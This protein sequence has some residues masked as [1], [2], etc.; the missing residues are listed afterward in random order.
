MPSTETEDL[1]REG[2][3]KKM[4]SRMFMKR[5]GEWWTCF[6]EGRKG[7]I[8]WASFTASG[9]VMEGAGDQFVCGQC[10]EK[11][12]TLTAFLL[13]KVQ[14]VDMGKPGGCPLCGMAFSRQVSLQEH[15]HRKHS[16]PELKNNS[17][18]RRGRPRNRH[19]ENE[20]SCDKRQGPGDEVRGGSAHESPAAQNGVGEHTV[21]VA[22]EKVG[23]GALSPLSPSTLHN[24]AIHDT[25]LLYPPTSATVIVEPCRDGEFGHLLEPVGAVNGVAVSPVPMFQPDSLHPQADGLQNASDCVPASVALPDSSQTL[26]NSLDLLLSHHHHCAQTDCLARHGGVKEHGEDE[27][28]ATF[29]TVRAESCSASFSENPSSLSS[30]TRGEHLPVKSKTSR[31]TK[32][33]GSSS[34]Q[35]E[36][37]NDF[38]FILVTSHVKRKSLSY[39]KQSFGCLHCRYKT[40]WRRALVRHMRET[41]ADHLA[42]H[43]CIAVSNSQKMHGQQVMKMSDYLVVLARQRKRDNVHRSRGV[44]RQDL[45]GY[46]P[47]GKCDKVFGR[48]RYLRKHQVIHKVEKKFLCDDCGKA[49]K[50]KAYLV[51]HRHTHQAK[52]YRCGQCDF[53]SSI[54]PLIHTHRQLH[55]H[56]S[57]ICDV[58]GSAYNDRAT[59]KKHKQVHDKTR[60]Y[61][62][63]YL[64]CTWRF[65]TEMMCRAHYRAHTTSGRFVCHLCS[66][67]FRHKHHLQRHLSKIHG[68]DEA[69][70]YRATCSTKQAPANAAKSLE[71]LEETCED[72]E[73]VEGLK[74]D[75]HPMSDT[76][77]LIVNTGLSSEQ[78]QS[79][80]ES[81]QFVIHTEDSE[82]SVNYEIANIA[83]DVSYDALTDA[84]AGTTCDGQTVFIPNEAVCSQIIFQHDTDAVPPSVET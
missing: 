13:H 23:G 52:V 51:A 68:M 64:G 53:T 20:T 7:G 28:D 44:E 9:Q 35:E 41:H 49:F 81:G 5:V 79:V 76:V 66:Y 16:I 1:T 43:Q 34:R 12:D 71:A 77:S 48:L 17:G 56:N 29:P 54:T 69:T 38:V 78:L 26:D 60:P 40:F 8:Q 75:K 63:D 84:S 4:R 59:L 47:C 6:L 65:K 61:P 82:N 32:K 31:S 39:S 18:K 80:L 37:E 11:V 19:I 74:D 83:M 24:P 62:C 50:T 2:F 21:S 72:K 14:H 33:S 42:V 70:V 57:V 3:E 45:P 67:V 36:G 73:Y 58:C 22:M 10:Q 30:Q 55:N 46:H 15:L 25:P 27:E